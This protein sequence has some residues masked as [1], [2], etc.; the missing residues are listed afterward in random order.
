MFIGDKGNGY[1]P[2]PEKQ[3][4]PPGGSSAVV[5][6]TGTLRTYARGAVAIAGENDVTRVAIRRVAGYLCEQRR[7]VQGLPVLHFDSVQPN[8]RRA[9]LDWATDL[10]RIVD[11]IQGDKPPTPYEL[12]CVAQDRSVS[13]ARARVKCQ[14]SEHRHMLGVWRPVPDRPGR[15]LAS[16]LRC[17]AGALIDM[18]SG[19]ESVSDALLTDCPEARR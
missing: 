15:E 10:L 18:A 13:A 17:A 4:P 19:C 8:E 7:R 14:A 2:M 1:K 12:A 16:C 6:P 3:G 11:E 5:E 9:M